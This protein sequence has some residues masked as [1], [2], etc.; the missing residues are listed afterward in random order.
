MK[1]IFKL[2]LKKKSD[3]YKVPVGAKFLEFHMQGYNY[4]A[5]YEFDTTVQLA[6][7]VC[8]S[9]YGTGVEIPLHETYIK[10]IFDGPMVWHLYS[11]HK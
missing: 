9:V 11:S 4:F 7:D 6:E 10:T 2:Q 3:W 8:L 5:W 1:K